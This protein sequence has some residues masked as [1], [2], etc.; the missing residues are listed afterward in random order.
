MNTLFALLV[1]CMCYLFV[2]YLILVRVWVVALTFVWHRFYVL[3]SVLH[4]CSKLCLL[5]AHETH[6]DHKNKSVNAIADSMEDETF[7]GEWEVSLTCF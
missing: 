7:N 5:K 1:L 3:F 6:P 4:V 2:N